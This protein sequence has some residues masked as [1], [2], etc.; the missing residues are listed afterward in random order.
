MIKLQ[1]SKEVIKL[2]NIKVDS[3]SNKI[4]FVE[5]NDVDIDDIP[6]EYGKFTIYADGSLYYDMASK[7]TRSRLGGSTVQ[8]V[9]YTLPDNVTFVNGN[10]N[11]KGITDWNKDGYADD[12]DL[13][14]SM[15][16]TYLHQG[17]IYS[18]RTLVE[19]TEAEQERAI[20]VAKTFDKNGNP[21]FLS[22]GSALAD[23]TY[24]EK[25]LKVTEDIGRLKPS[26][27]S[28]G[29]VTVN[30]TGKS[31]FEVMKDILQV[32]KQPRI[33]W[34]LLYGR[35]TFTLS[36][37]ATT[38]VTTQR[39][40]DGSSTIPMATYNAEIGTKIKKVELFLKLINE[41]SQ[42]SYSYGPSPTGVMITRI[43]SYKFADVVTNVNEVGGNSTTYAVNVTPTGAN[44]VWLLS[45]TLLGSI[46]M[47]TTQ[48]VKA[49]NNL[50]EEADP[51][52]RIP[53]YSG[54]L[55]Q[56]NFRSLPYRRG[57]FMGGLKNI[58]GTALTSANV[59]SLASRK[60]GNFAAEIVTMTVAAG[61]TIVV[62]AIPSGKKI[63]KIENVTAGFPDVKADFVKRTISVGGADASGSNLG[64]CAADYDVYYY[65][66]PTG[67]YVNAT[68][69]KVTLAH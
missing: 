35:L 19:G 37:G 18:A 27:T 16:G 28:A 25:D 21:V 29:F 23:Q 26:Q 50:D 24:F 11:Y 13:S 52:V 32:P 33:D 60:N 46:S 5:A 38:T 34:P 31:A 45:E 7:K 14:Q 59:R 61:N 58:N 68:T 15:L 67:A 47:N 44:S 9:D 4:Q 49:M 30:M 22:D 48:G 42:G 8:Y 2:S 62:V 10:K 3:L 36:T 43:G 66:P 17:D 39:K 63:T 53:A 51:E 56:I 20:V 64:E 12:K 55:S 1:Y 65:Q 69:F 41:G 57:Y 6:V 40:L 54:S